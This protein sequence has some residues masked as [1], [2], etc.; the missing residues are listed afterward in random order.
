MKIKIVLPIDKG[1]LIVK[2]YNFFSLDYYKIFY[3]TILL[4]VNTFLEYI[5][6][7]RLTKYFL[8]N[9]RYEHIYITNW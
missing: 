8:T 3:G 1:K 6:T 9:C 7:I 2:Y 4:I 5:N